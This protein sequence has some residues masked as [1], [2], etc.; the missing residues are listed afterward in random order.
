MWHG[1]H[2]REPRLVTSTQN[3]TVAKWDS[4]QKSNPA[5]LRPMKTENDVGSDAA[6]FGRD[7]NQETPARARSEFSSAQGRIMQ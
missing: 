6:R 2:A 5:I 3:V 1:R 7:R 4:H